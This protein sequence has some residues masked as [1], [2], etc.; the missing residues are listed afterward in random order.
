MS[1]SLQPTENRTAQELVRATLRKAIMTG[2]IPSGTRLAQTELAAQLGFS[3]TPVREALRGLAAEGLIRLDAHRGAV[4]NEL[5]REELDD[6][7]RLRC[8]LEPEALRRAVDRITKEELERANQLEQEMRKAKSADRWI[9]LNAE[10]HRV[11]VSVAGSHRLAQIL[12]SLQDSFAMYIV[13]SHAL[14]DVRRADAEQQHLELLEAMRVGDA[15]K[16][17]E[18]MIE[19]LNETRTHVLD[20]PAFGDVGEADA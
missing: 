13:A 2:Q 17:V 4:V 1:L 15:E 9:D 19:H 10:F 3:T 8:L 6:V 11:F 5:S 18:V 14:D 16:A 7:Y 12:S 20:M